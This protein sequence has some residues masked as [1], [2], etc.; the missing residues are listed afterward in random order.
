MFSLLE[1]R[2]ALIDCQSTK[3]TF[4]F[5]SSCHIDG[6]K[7]ILTI[8]SD[9]IMRPVITAESVCLLLMHEIYRKMFI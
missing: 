9:A 4:I 7:D 1:R 3:D 8:I 5:A 2:G 6:V